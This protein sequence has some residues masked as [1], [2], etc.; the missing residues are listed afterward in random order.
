LALKTSYGEEPKI[1]KSRVI[2][3]D[4]RS[5]VAEGGVVD[6]ELRSEGSR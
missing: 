6:E 5:D 1:R 4:Q 3:K 2:A